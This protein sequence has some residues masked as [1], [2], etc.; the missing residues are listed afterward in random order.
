MSGEIKHGLAVLQELVER[1]VNDVTC[2]G[3]VENNP[4]IQ[5]ALKH[6]SGY[7]TGTAAELIDNVA[8][9]A[10]SPF[11]DVNDLEEDLLL[12]AVACINTIIAG[13]LADAQFEDGGDDSGGP[14]APRFEAEVSGKIM[15]DGSISAGVQTKLGAGPWPFPEPHDYT[16]DRVAAELRNMGYT[17]VPLH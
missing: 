13:R 5:I 16:M 1:I 3:D 12:A 6:G 4:F 9:N 11:V 17:V 2:A 15:N 10:G 8:D 7:L 14:E